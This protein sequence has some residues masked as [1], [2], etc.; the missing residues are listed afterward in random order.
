MAEIIQ[1]KGT[2]AEVARWVDATHPE[3]FETDEDGNRTGNYRSYYD[4]YKA[5]H[6]IRNLVL[7][8]GEYDE[9]GNEITPP[10]FGGPALMD[11]YTKGT[12]LAAQQTRL[13]A[14]ERARDR[15]DPTP[16]RDL[17]DPAVE[18]VAVFTRRWSGEEGNKERIPQK[19]SRRSRSEPVRGRR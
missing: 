18:D 3:L 10:T 15:G 4:H 17:G 11:F 7:V 2:R 16:T 1:L 19:P 8:F 5:L 6:F 9:D 13:E 14:R 12:E